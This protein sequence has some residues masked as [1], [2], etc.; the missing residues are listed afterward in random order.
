MMVKTLHVWVCPGLSWLALIPSKYDFCVY[1]DLPE[2]FAS[3]EYFENLMTC[4]CVSSDLAFSQ[5]SARHSKQRAKSKLHPSASS[6]TC[7]SVTLRAWERQDSYRAWT[8]KC[9]DRTPASQRPLKPV[10]LLRTPSKAHCRPIHTVTG[11]STS[12][13]VS[14]PNHRA[15]CLHGQQLV[16]LISK[17]LHPG[18]QFLRVFAN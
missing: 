17:L 12:P 8:V 5:P 9:P 2:S 3:Y 6:S 1:P 18:V 14:D 15:C 16:T 7:H 13:T 10:N 4:A 11:P